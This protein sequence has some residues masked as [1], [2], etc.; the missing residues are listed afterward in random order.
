MFR[1]AFHAVALYRS[2]VCS[3]AAVACKKKGRRNDVKGS[4]GRSSTEFSPSSPNGASVNGA[5]RS[6]LGDIDAAKAS[7]G[8]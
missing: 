2:D 6:T 8:S 1:C 7:L 5:P 4:K 3:S